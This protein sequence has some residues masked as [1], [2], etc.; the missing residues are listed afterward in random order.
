MS[1]KS[2]SAVVAVNCGAWVEE[3][4]LARKRAQNHKSS[5]R[6]RERLRLR[7]CPSQRA[8]SN[9]EAG[10][11]EPVVPDEA[12]LKPRAQSTDAREGSAHHGSPTPEP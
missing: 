7:A 12:E 5:A 3:S 1:Q 4:F 11:S 6:C 2:E 10:I 8:N 9:N